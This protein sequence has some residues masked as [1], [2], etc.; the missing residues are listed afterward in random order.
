MSIPQT[1]RP[2]PR[3]PADDAHGY[4]EEGFEPARED[5]RARAD[6]ERVPPQDIGAEQCVLGGMQLSKDAIAD[7]TE[8]LRSSCDFYRPA[9]ALIYDAI[10]DM[11]GRGEPVDPITLAA[12]LQKSGS[13]DRIGGAPYLHTLVQSV[14]T[15]ANAAYYAGIV[16]ERAVFRGL[17]EAGTRIT[18]W[19]YACEGDPAETADRAQAE[20]FAVVE[21]GTK[22]D[23]LSLADTALDGL[24]ALEERAMQ[25]AGL[26]GL[27]TGFVDLDSVTSGL[28]P[29][30]MVIVAARP[31]LG[32]ST[33][34]LDIARN[35][36]IKEKIPSAFFSL[37]MSRQELTDRTFSAE[38][39][40]AFH[41]VKS[42]EMTDEDWDRLARRM[43]DIQS[44]PL[45]IDDT[46]DMT[47]MEI[48]AK[49][50]K[51]KQRHG[52]K[53]VVID[54]VQLL[55]HGGR[56]AEN[57][58]Q[59]VTEISRNIKLM[60]KELGVP[61]IALCQLNRGPEQRTDKKPQVSDLRESGSLEQDAD[62]VI[63][64][65]RE[66]AYEADSPRAGE[67]DLILAKHRG[68]PKCTITVA[69]Q[70]HMSRFKDMAQ[71]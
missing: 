31:S 37:E 61:V 67:T 18:Q 28:M 21:E 45:F 57:R 19:G 17:T 70:L 14:P 48:R 69:A 71:V 29:G 43:P 49:A 9:H 11:Y 25:G 60:A 40:I 50:R 32:K 6:F 64:I 23:P 33:F 54:Y 42:G 52:I 16:R 1:F 4:G 59:E 30:Q 39:G 20:L 2:E 38:A 24:A 51:L 56:Q 12:E 36:S 53:L 7:V 34:A 46:E 35:V 63:L 41:H 13:L 66:D 3:P 5:S 47:V 8:V 44:A 58:Q 65:H 10:L 22:G 62:I 15:A 55:R 27:G 26:R 68:G